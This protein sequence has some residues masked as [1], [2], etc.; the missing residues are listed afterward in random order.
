MDNGQR[1]R[2]MMLVDLTRAFALRWMEACRRGRDLE[3]RVYGRAQC[4]QCRAAVSLV[5]A[6]ERNRITYFCPRC[7]SREARCSP[8]ARGS[9]LQGGCPR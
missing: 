6:G 4:M 3:K 1:I 8:R 2:L 7:Q 9:A 5:R